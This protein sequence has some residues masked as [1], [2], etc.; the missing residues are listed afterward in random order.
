MLFV[1]LLSN[2]D[3][4]LVDTCVTKGST[5]SML[6]PYKDEFCCCLL[7]DACAIAAYQNTDLCCRIAA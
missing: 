4:V 7:I 1:H 3:L 5:N 6:Q 2:L